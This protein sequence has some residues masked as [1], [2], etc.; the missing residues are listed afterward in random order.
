MHVTSMT[1]LDDPSASH[2]GALSRSRMRW[3]ITWGL[4][5]AVLGGVLTYLVNPLLPTTYTAQSQVVVRS[6]GE[7]TLFD[8]AASGSVASASVA[9]GELMRSPDVA[10]AASRRLDG[11]LTP[12][13]VRRQVTVATD[14]NSPIV[15]VVAA[16]A[17]DRLARD[18]ANA[19]PA[20]YLELQSEDAADRADRAK[21]QLEDLRK[22]QSDRLV[23]VQAQMAG[24]VNNVRWGSPPMASSVDFANYV[25]ATLEADTAYQEFKNEAAG[26]TARIAEIDT[27]IQQGDVDAALLANGVDRVIAAQR[28]ESPAS[29]VLPKNEIVG[30]LL[31]LIIGV[32]FAW[33][34]TER[35]R[36]LE[37]PSVASALG[38]PLLGRF[39]PERQ[40]RRF[41]RFADFATDATLG[42]ELKVLT[43]S[44]L[45][46]ARRNNIG[47][48]VITSARTREG[49]SALAANV[50][51]AADFTGH[52]V[53]LVDASTGHPTPSERF[54]FDDAAGLSELLEGGPLADS[55]QELR[56][57][58]G[59]AMPFVPSGVHPAGEEL[60]RR[61]SEN[62][63][64]VWS[65]TFRG[66]DAP[67]A[68]VDAPA[69]ND[70]PLPLQLAGA[71]V[72]VVVVSPRITL[73]DL[74]V[75]RNRAEAADVTVLGFI[76]NEFRAGRPHRRAQLARDRRR[77]Q[78]TRD[79][80][81]KELAL[82]ASE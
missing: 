57:T 23:L 79:R 25:Q 14:S 50:A 67:V 36:A 10:A 76:L 9:A 78:R 69:V 18:L 4:I 27:A 35:R 58:D 74:E 33:W 8:K 72:L 70:H 75:L 20:A 1:T 55:V 41:P 16:A 49:K 51:A 38:A 2:S 54:G 34:A 65:N 24:E 42:N 53:V 46:S 17:T 56:Y 44:L 52:D 7:I 19:V 45:L 26:L 68:V 15:T 59:R 82:S 80:E 73:F 12:G 60:G 37:A 77:L 29:P 43:S 22:D 21:S 31:G 5:G 3:Y 28:P 30:V 63:R 64:A 62:R 13:E 32:G 66:T 48:I 11:R 39:G 40:L 61:L 6:P 81:E 47:S 71:G